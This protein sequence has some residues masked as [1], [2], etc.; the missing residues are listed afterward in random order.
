MSQKVG[1]F[2]RT[3]RVSFMLGAVEQAGQ[4]GG[5]QGTLLFEHT[6]LCED[7]CDLRNRLASESALGVLVRRPAGIHLPVIR[8]CRHQTDAPEGIGR[9]HL[10]GGWRRGAS[11]ARPEGAGVAAQKTCG[12]PRSRFGLG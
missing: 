1:Q 3:A 11:L 5:G 10:R 2:R 4:G 8:S 7:Q 12:I 9:A 6:R